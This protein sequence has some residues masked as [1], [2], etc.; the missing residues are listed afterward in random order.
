MRDKFLKES[1]DN[2]LA[3]LEDINTR[4]ESIELY[5]RHKQGDSLTSEEYKRMVDL[6]NMDGFDGEGG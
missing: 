1:V 3:L 4:L 6:G 5:L 2:A